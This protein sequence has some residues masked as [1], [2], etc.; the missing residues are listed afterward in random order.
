MIG[1]QIKGRSFSGLLNYLSAKEG[2]QLIGGNMA[3][4]NPLQLTAEF[5]VSCQLNPR[6]QRVVYHASLSLPKHERLDGDRWNLVAADYLK[7]MGFD[8]NQYAVYRHIDRDHDHIHI[9]ASR[10]RLTD[11]STVSDSWDYV[12]SEKLIRHLEK[13]YSLQRTLSSWEKTKTAPTTGQV[14]RLMR[15]DNQFSSGQRA[16]PAE[17]PAIAKV[18]ISIQ[19]ALSAKTFTQYINKL[20]ESGVRVIPSVADDGR[21][22]GIVYSVDGLYFKASKLGHKRKPTLKGLQESGIDFDLERDVVPLTRAL[23]ANDDTQS[24]IESIQELIMFN[25]Q[26]L[27][28]VKLASPSKKLADGLLLEHMQR[29]QVNNAILLSQ[30]VYRQLSEDLSQL[31]PDERDKEVAKRLLRHNYGPEEVKKILLTSPSDRTSK[32]AGEL[33]IKALLELQH[34][35]TSK[36][37]SQIEY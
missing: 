12:R 36:S 34:E 11:G 20:S 31:I 27:K 4:S 19:N 26:N 33:A 28:L 1:K 25:P 9:V 10:I 16:S 24:S 6:L 15:E 21:I 3:G 35:A 17:L 18:Q 2:A 37:R 22:N 14:R 13:K 5:R 7:G 8:S 30:Q 32:E 29:E 23:H